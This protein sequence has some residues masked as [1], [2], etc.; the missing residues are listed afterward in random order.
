MQAPLVNVKP[1]AQPQTAF[2]VV[3]QADTTVCC[4]PLQAAQAVHGFRPE[5]LQV[6]PGA[7]AGTNC[8]TSAEESARL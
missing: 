6:T 4:A 5:A 1:A 8:A 3:V 2:E 7:H